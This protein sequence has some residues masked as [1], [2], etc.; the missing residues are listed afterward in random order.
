MG[1]FLGL[2]PR[3]ADDYGF[4]HNDNHQRNI[5][6]GADGIALI[7][8]DCAMRQ[9]F[10]H[11]VTT[12]LQGLM[13]EEAGGMLSPLKD[14]A[15]LRRFLSCSSRKLRENLTG[16]FWCHG[17]RNL[18]TT[19]GFFSFPTCR[20]GWI[21]SR[22]EKAPANIRSLLRFGYSLPPFPRARAQNEGSAMTAMRSR[23]LVQ[24]ATSRGRGFR[25]FPSRVLGTPHSSDDE[26]RRI[27]RS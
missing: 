16:S 5:L 3:S 1:A 27:A 25:K 8:F 20:T 22:T 10:L 2:L 14:E 21:P 12:P 11:D 6:A 13:F 9:F 7:D 19:G 18:S 23:I 17:S 24:S 26:R 15:R 4:I